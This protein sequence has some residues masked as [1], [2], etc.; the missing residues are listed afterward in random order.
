MLE[1][2]NR[3]IRLFSRKYSW[4]TPNCSLWVFHIKFSDEE[5]KTIVNLVQFLEVFK[6]VAA[7][8]SGSKF[9]YYISLVLLFKSELEDYRRVAAESRRRSMTCTHRVSTGDARRWKSA[10][11]ILLNVVWLALQMSS[12][13]LLPFPSYVQVRFLGRETVNRKSIHIQR[14][15]PLT[16]LDR[17]SQILLLFVFSWNGSSLILF[18]LSSYMP[19]QFLGHVT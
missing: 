12:L 5:W 14:W 10:P 3:D 1:Y 11:L 6:T 4:A 8:L 9:P 18:L 17:R 13:C 15:T 16:S 7:V 19:V 2:W